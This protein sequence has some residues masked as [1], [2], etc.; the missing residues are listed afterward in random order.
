M[1]LGDLGVTLRGRIALRRSCLMHPLHQTGLVSNKGP[2]S[3]SHPVFGGMSRRA[4][5]HDS[6]DT[7]LPNQGSHTDVTSAKAFTNMITTGSP[8]ERGGYYSGFPA[9][10]AQFEHP[11]QNGLYNEDLMQQETDQRCLLQSS[12]TVINSSLRFLPSLPLCNLS[13][14][15]LALEPRPTKAAHN[16][17]SSLGTIKA[18]GACG[19]YQISIHIVWWVYWLVL[20]QTL[21][22]PLVVWSLRQVL[23]RF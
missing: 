20:A 10:I 13:S 2:G 5:S 4:W 6:H 18:K 7:E 21:P 19:E 16:P 1:G 22:P 9:Y 12:S 8:D 14:T 3:L 15:S 11:I 17:K 23:N